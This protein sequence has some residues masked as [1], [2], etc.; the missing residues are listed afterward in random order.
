MN[1]YTIGSGHY[2][3]GNSETEHTRLAAQAEFWGAA[4]RQALSQAG[5]ATGMSVLD[6]GCGT[7]AAMRLMAGFVGATG[8]VTGIDRDTKLGESMLESLRRDG[9][10][11][12][13]FVGADINKV[14]EVK[15]SPFDLVFVRLLLI[16]LADPVAVLRKLWAWVRPGGALIVMDHDW[17][18]WRLIPHRPVFD[19]AIQV[20]RDSSKAAGL[21]LEIGAHMPLLFKQAGIE[22]PDSCTVAGFILPA[23]TSIKM[24][25]A[26]LA[27]ARPTAIKLGVT[28]E[29]EGEK[30]DLD[31]EA[32][33]RDDD[34]FMR[35]FDMTVTM[36][37]KPP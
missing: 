35:W 28:T 17:H 5:L 27:S 10:D 13:T 3:L 4:T 14:S 36:K 29:P 34:V 23:D 31:L 9:P 2:A 32:L 33:Q 11:V 15:G 20:V 21:N 19:R 18:S 16:H 22:R 7:G 25:R 1:Q 37:R 24:L 8:R 26:V 30:L 6:V 12:F